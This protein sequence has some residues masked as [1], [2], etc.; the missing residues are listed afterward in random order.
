MKPNGVFG[1]FQDSVMIRA[2][3][4]LSRVPGLGWGHFGISSNGPKE[5]ASLGYKLKLFGPGHFQILRTP[6]ALLF[7]TMLSFAL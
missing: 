7:E 4:G 5:S 6:K 1:C 2:L 3:P